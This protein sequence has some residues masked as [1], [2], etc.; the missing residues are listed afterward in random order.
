[1]VEDLPSW[2]EEVVD[3]LQWRIEVLWEWEVEWEC[4]LEEGLK[5]G[6]CLVWA[7][8]EPVVQKVAKVAGL[9][10]LLWV[11]LQLLAWRPVVVR[12]MLVVEVVVSSFLVG[13]TQVLPAEVLGLEAS[14]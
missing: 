6:E 1:M 2:E 9:D 14:K 4:G 11:A 7:V 10:E 5:Q 13:S 12:S 8:L 3:Q